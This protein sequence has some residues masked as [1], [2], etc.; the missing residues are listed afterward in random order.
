[1]KYTKNTAKKVLN[2]LN[3]NPE[4]KNEFLSWDYEAQKTSVKLLLALKKI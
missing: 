3:N 2:Y 1:M 4:F